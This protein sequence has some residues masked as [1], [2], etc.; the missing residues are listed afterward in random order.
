[1]A[2]LISDFIKDALSRRIHN[3]PENQELGP[4]RC[5]VCAPELHDQD[6]GGEA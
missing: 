5:P 3:E 4:C 6:E 1:M 2:D